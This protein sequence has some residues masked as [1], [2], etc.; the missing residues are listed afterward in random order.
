MTKNNKIFIKID[1]N[2][3][4]CATTQETLQHKEG[5]TKSED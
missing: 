4:S 1:L 5:K 3:R 2:F